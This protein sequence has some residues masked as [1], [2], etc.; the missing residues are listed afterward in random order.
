MDIL[1]Q[2]IELK[3]RD[4]EPLNIADMMKLVELKFSNGLKALEC[5]LCK[6]KVKN[7]EDEGTKGMLEDC[8]TV[9]LH[10]FNRAEGAMWQMEK[11]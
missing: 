1:D 11:G 8:Y 9:M 7:E 10:A 6:M 5:A 2:E 4:I 3:V